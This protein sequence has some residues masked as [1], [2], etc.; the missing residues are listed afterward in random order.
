[1]TPKGWSDVK[2]EFLAGLSW[3][4]DRSKPNDDAF[5]HSERIAAVFDGATNVGD[6]VLPADSDAAWI[7][8]KGAE[9]LIAHEAL[10]AREALRLAAVDAERDFVATR[11]RAPAERYEMPLAAMTLAA[12]CGGGIEFLWFGDCAGLVK[13]PG[14]KTELVGEAVE[15]RAQE[16]RH[17]TRLAGQKGIAPAAGVNRPEF[18]PALRA[19]R[20]GMNVGKHWAFAPETHCVDHVSSAIV[21]AEDGT[22]LLLCS[23]GFLAL[24]SDYGRYDADTLVEAALEHGL[25]PLMEELR[26]I[27]DGDPEG[28][29]FPR[30][31]KSDDATALVLRLIPD[32]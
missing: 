10:G 18:L 8:R 28:R 23:D 1:M 24:A 13:R 25:R 15:A 26:T 29:K 21:P 31:K 30:F 22:V 6:P 3:P 7:A 12:P 11:L 5:C 20:N 4:G 17:A 19:S 16:G 32:V 2:F 14:R 27:E 9:G